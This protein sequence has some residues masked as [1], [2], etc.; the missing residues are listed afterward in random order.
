MRISKSG[1]GLKT[2]FN[3]TGRT[4]DLDSED[5]DSVLVKILDDKISNTN[6]DSQFGETEFQNRFKGRVSLMQKDGH[7]GLVKRTSQPIH[8]NVNSGS[9]TSS[10]QINQNNRKMPE[11][12]ENS[13][14]F[15]LKEY[16]NHSL[17]RFYQI[18]TS[19]AQNPLKQK[20]SLPTLSNY[21]EAMNVHFNNQ[22]A[23]QVS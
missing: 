4:K 19:L 6:Q 10:S 13:R 8:K 7:I 14:N 1:L 18:P 3:D 23:G 11:M 17:D 21:Y 20:S 16:D 9:P 15:P 5:P 12:G 22:T 2:E